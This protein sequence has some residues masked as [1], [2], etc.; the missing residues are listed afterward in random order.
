MSSRELAARTRAVQEHPDDPGRWRQLAAAAARA[1]DL[2][3]ARVALEAAAGLDGH[4]L[5]EVQRQAAALGLAPHDPRRLLP[6]GQEPWWGL[7]SPL[8]G[9]LAAPRPQVAPG[10]AVVAFLGRGEV[11]FFD[12]TTAACLA[13]VPTGESSSV[14]RWQSPTCFAWLRRGTPKRCTV[15]SVEVP[16]L[17]RGY[18]PA[19]WLEASEHRQVRAEVH[20]GDVRGWLPGA[21]LNIEVPF[22]RTTRT[23]LLRIAPDG[24]RSLHPLPLSPSV[25]DVAWTALA[26]PRGQVLV[27]RMTG[28]AAQARRP[29]SELAVLDLGSPGTPLAPSSTARQQ[30]RAEAESAATHHWMLDLALEPRA[31]TEAGF[32][33]VIRDPDS[34]ETRRAELRPEPD[35]DPTWSLAL[36]QDERLVGL[37]PDGAVLLSREGRAREVD[38]E[39]GRPRARLP[40]PAGCLAYPLDEDR[41]LA[42]RPGRFEVLARGSTARPRFLRPRADQPGEVLALACAP[43]PPR[44]A[45]WYTTGLLRLSD[46]VTGDPLAERRLTPPRFED[47][48]PVARARVLA[49]DRAGRRLLVP[50]LRGALV[51]DATT[52]APVFEAELP[53][54]LYQSRV[55][56]A[57]LSAT[58]LA[59]GTGN[60]ELVLYDLQDGTPRHQADLDARGAALDQLAFHPDGQGLGALCAVRRLM[61]ELDPAGEAVVDRWRFGRRPDPR[62]ASLAVASPQGYRIF[63][64]TNGVLEL[65]RGERFASQ[66]WKVKPR[67]AYGVGH[68]G[69]AMVA[70]LDADLVAV[71]QRPGSSMQQVHLI[72][73]SDGR[74]VGNLRVSWCQAGL[75]Q[76]ALLPGTRTLFLADGEAVH[77][78][79][80]PGPRPP[81]ADRDQAPHP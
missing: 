66:L 6:P 61:W 23:N 75:G 79:E 73:L 24:R 41:L 70:D 38:L 63:S 56:S 77:R 55:T 34:P 62:P 12:S 10:G 1:D 76:A 57:A 15:E 32:L 11:A 5:A 80:V 42:V 49:F 74:E 60:G 27:T 67:G 9:T 72:Q 71:G 44:L 47:P 53:P 43:D 58:T 25:G 8:Q 29:R 22:G 16:D 54:A 33:V 19:S 52:L 17:P 3:L 26:G 65:R 46:P 50:R 35:Q 78:V 69:Y 4:D 45:V 2:G 31:W 7:D 81:R 48:Q 40:L 13:R 21:A 64:A 59:L 39:T 68:A 30:H 36:D 14:G 20:R 18:A 51:L 28:A 37:L